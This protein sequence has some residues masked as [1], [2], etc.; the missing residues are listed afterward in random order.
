MTTQTHAHIYTYT[1]TRMHTMLKT[2]RADVEKSTDKDNIDMMHGTC[3]ISTAHK[4]ESF[5]TGIFTT[6]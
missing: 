5:A 6:Q 4:T 1:H 3:R 2:N